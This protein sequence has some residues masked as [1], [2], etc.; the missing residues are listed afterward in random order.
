MS[1]ER[2]ELVFVYNAG[3]TAGA[4]AVDLLHKAI[5]PGT[6]ACNLCRVTNGVL[7]MKKEWRRFLDSLALT[8]TFSYRDEFAKS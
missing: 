8:V 3:S 2:Q 1:G 7:A 4:R 5:S 6:Y